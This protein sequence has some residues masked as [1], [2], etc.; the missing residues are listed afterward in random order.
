MRLGKLSNAELQSLILDK[1]SPRNVEVL[2]SS[3]LAEDCALLRCDEFI[4]A[5]T[6]PITA[7]QEGQGSLA[8]NVSANDIFSSGG[9][10]FAAL[11]TLLIPPDCD[12]DCVNKVMQDI[13]S[14]AGELGI[15]IVGGHTEYT[16]AVTR[17]VVSV[18]MLG[19][20]TR[21]VASTSM[22]VGDS[23]LVTKDVGLEGTAILTSDMADSLSSVITAAEM[24]EVQRFR[25]EISI[26]KECSILSNLAHVTA[27][28]DI[29]EGGIIGAIAEMCES[30]S[31]GCILEEDSIPVRDIT[32]RVCAHLGLN[33][34]RLISSGSLLFTTACPTDAIERLSNQGIKAT[35]VGTITDSDTLLHTP[36]GY[37]NITTE[38]DQL[39]KIKE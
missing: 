10:P 35:V 24:T 4:L 38:S 14:R 15:D 2:L 16:D 18:T 26:E 36:S 1:L 11:V 31:L 6:D 37:A 33:P 21:P 8:I 13:T 7:A 19:K 30:A 34:Y 17:I 3:K 32:R 27:M 28:H 9:T 39:F 12:S 29:T 5:T 23:I 22:T 20:T 25:D